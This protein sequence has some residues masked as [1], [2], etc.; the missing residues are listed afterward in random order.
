VRHEEA[1]QPLAHQARHVVAVQPVV[2]GI[3][4]ALAQVT[5]AELG[6]A[7]AHAGADVRD[8]LPVP[9]RQPQEDAVHVEEG[10]QQRLLVALAHAVHGEG[11]VAQVGVEG[12]QVAQL[13][14]LRALE[15]LHVVLHGVQPAQHQVEDAH[16][17]AQVVGQLLDHHREGAGHLAQHALAVHLRGRRG[18]GEGRGESAA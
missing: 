13:V 7:L 5:P 6:H 1:G 8:D 18:R 2:R 3:R 16:C 4:G 14:L 12:A 10:L 17:G 9:R 15:G 11:G